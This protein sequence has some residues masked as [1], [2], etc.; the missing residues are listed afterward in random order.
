MARWA[1]IIDLRKCIACEACVT[2]CRQVSRQPPGPTWRK[3][4][5]LEIQDN[6]SKKQLFLTMS[7]MHCA[8][9]TCMEVCPTGATYRRPDG[10]VDIDLNLCMGCGAC[11]VAC[12]YHARAISVSD[13]ILTQDEKNS[14]TVNVNNKDRIGVCTKC[15]FCLQHV[16]AGLA[17]GLKPGTD[18][19]CTPQ[20]VR[21]CLSGSLSF[22][23]MDDPDSEVSELIRDNEVMGMLEELGTEPSVYYI[24]P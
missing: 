5:E 1:M 22:G 7:C 10:I 15:N 13:T 16:D 9:P 21:F 2:I 8:K 14:Q 12:P 24:L 23:D 19:E 4:A 17:K 11:V 20:C 3:L 6:P 18:P